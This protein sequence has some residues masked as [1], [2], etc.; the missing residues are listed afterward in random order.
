MKEQ[1]MRRPPAIV[2][3]LLA[4]MPALAL[5]QTKSPPPARTAAT[6]AAQ[7]K[8]PGPV[9]NTPERTTASFGDW[10]LRCETIA[11]QAKRVCEVAL[12]M[13][14]Q[15]QTNPVAQVAIGKPVPNESRR[16]T[17]VLPTNIAIGTRPQ[18]TLAQ[19]GAA[20]IELT[21]QRCAP[22]A[23]FAS[24]ALADETITMFGAQTEPGRLVFKDAADREVALPLSFRGLP[25]ALAALAKEQ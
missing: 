2:A 5:A 3:A 8:P 21:W 15:G 10:V 25:Q 20:P 22:G 24:A 6:A 1:L 16:L 23:C 18:A 13:S 9:G 11:E 7:P 4:V 19:A 17:L 14:V 12:V